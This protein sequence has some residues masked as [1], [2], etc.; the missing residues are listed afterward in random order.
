MLYKDTKSTAPGEA[1]GEMM[2]Y[3]HAFVPDG[4]Y[5]FLWTHV[6][7]LRAGQDDR[8]EMAELVHELAQPIWRDLYFKRMSETLNERAPDL[9]KAS[10]TVEEEAQARSLV[11][12]PGAIFG[13][14][15]GKTTP[16]A[17]RA[18]ADTTGDAERRQRTC[19]ADFYIGIYRLQNGD[20]AA[21]RAFLQSAADGCA[22]DKMEARLAATELARLGP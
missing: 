18:A 14:F 20:R 7:R 11:P 22:P 17:V 4:Y 6:A 3:R 16:E 5:L 21:A 8:T 10:R 2:D 15:Q 19:D 9:Q 12:W 13:L 1:T